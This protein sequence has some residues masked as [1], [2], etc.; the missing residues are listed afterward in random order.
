MAFQREGDPVEM[1]ARSYATQLRCEAKTLGVELSL[2]EDTSDWDAIFCAEAQLLRNLDI[3][4]LKRRA[5]FVYSRYAE[6]AGAEKAAAHAVNAVDLEK[7]TREALVADLL[8]VHAETTRIYLL[9]YQVERERADL[10]RFVIYIGFGALA[11]FMTFISWAFLVQHIEPLWATVI[12]IVATVVLIVGM[13]RYEKYR[14]NKGRRAPTP[15]ATAALLIALLAVSPLTGQ[16]A[17]TTETG[18][19]KAPVVETSKVQQPAKTPVLT[20]KS[21]KPAK[22]VPPKVRRAGAKAMPRVPIAPLVILTGILGACFSVLQRV[23]RSVAG[24]PLV[25]L[26]SLRSARTHIFLSIISGAIASLVLFAVFTGKMIE[27]SLF[28]AIV[29]GTAETEK[30]M[31]LLYNFLSATG[32]ESAADYGKL[33]VW[34]FIAGFAERFVPDILDRF[35]TSTKKT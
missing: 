6:V 35:V 5:A 29:N 22:P 19:A 31:M 20:A 12:V 11:S 27:G 34:T 3:D 25:A 28:P 14:T 16:T 4:N 8:A 21:P 24:D 2:P 18:T 15:V 33:L 32:P 13:W 26:L 10:A 17:T 7:C 1:S 23:Q 30:S 9:G